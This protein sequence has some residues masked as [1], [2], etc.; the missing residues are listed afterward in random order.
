[1]KSDGRSERQFDAYHP[2]VYTSIM[3]RHTS[4]RLMV[5]G[6]LAV[7]LSLATAGDFVVDLVFEEPDLVSEASVE[8]PEGLLD[9]AEH[10]LVTSAGFAALSPDASTILP[11]AQCFGSEALLQAIVSTSSPAIPLGH[12]PPQAPVSFS[13]P[14]RI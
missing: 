11:F 5:V 1:M 12:P 13:I 14:L 2:A 6:W 4:S 7:L 9:P 8:I 10:L 3:L